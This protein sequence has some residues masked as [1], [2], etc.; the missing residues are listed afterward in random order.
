MADAIISAARNSTRG[1]GSAQL[2][3]PQNTGLSSVAT[4]IGKVADVIVAE[5]DKAAR[6]LAA[7]DDILTGAS[8]MGELKAAV[9]GRMLAEENSGNLA[10]PRNVTR[11][12]GEISLEVE[13]A[14]AQADASLNLPESQGNF[15]NSLAATAAGFGDDLF[16]KSTKAGRAA[17]GEL[18]RAK[19]SELSAV[20]AGNPAAYGEAV[21]SLQ[22][23][24]ETQFDPAMTP[25]ATAVAMQAGMQA[26]AVSR[27]NFYRANGQHQE[28]LNQ[29]NDPEVRPFLGPDKISEF[30]L[31]SYTGLAKD[32]KEAADSLDEKQDLADAYGGWDKVPTH[33]KATAALGRTVA[34]PKAGPRTLADKIAGLERAQGTPATK[35]QISRMA[36]AG[37]LETGADGSDNQTQARMRATLLKDAERLRSGVGTAQEVIDYVTTAAL[38][39]QS[40]PNPSLNELKLPA[41]TREVLDKYGIDP[42]DLN[43]PSGIAQLQRLRQQAIVVEQDDPEA[44][45]GPAATASQPGRQPPK[46]EAA[47]SVIRDD[48]QTMTEAVDAAPEVADEAEHVRGAKVLNSMVT[49][50]ISFFDQAHKLTGVFS[51]FKA[52]VADTEFL[53]RFFRQPEIA[54]LR[55]AFQMVFPVLAFAFREG[56]RF[57]DA[58]R[59]DLTERLQAVEGSFGRPPQSMQDSM[60]GLDDFLEGAANFYS[61]KLRTEGSLSEERAKDMT[62]RL[63]AIQLA[64]QALNV[65]PALRTRSLEAFQELIA[66]H[67][68]TPEDNVRI[69]FHVKTV[70]KVLAVFE[71][72]AAAKTKSGTE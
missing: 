56:E 48:V 47:V 36:G 55:Q 35:D 37:A 13:K 38:Y 71:S 17:M 63:T 20:V 12:R 44:Q 4:G 27:L 60:M 68:L 65:P 24:H 66:I 43:S 7:Q 53:G 34:A 45:D 61:D 42:Q 39:I 11:L 1:F 31:A 6:R 58:E 29:M 49:A 69:L 67:G 19:V 50:G 15:S 40:S 8:I 14:Q 33:V 16:D 41:V 23:F 26:L 28:V 25:D 57:A 30:A 54:G 72:Q 64:R 59:Q 5:E 21:A 46:I 52:A 32:E 62:D 9:R 51:G 2:Q 18:Q 70:K 3:V 10:D 22:R